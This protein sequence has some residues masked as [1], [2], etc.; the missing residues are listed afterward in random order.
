MPYFSWVGVH[1]NGQRKKGTLFAQSAQELDALLFKQDI[2]LLRSTENGSSWYVSTS[3]N[4]AVKIAFFRQL[5]VLLSAGVLLPQALVIV[6]AQMN[7]RYFQEIIHGLVRDVHHGLSLSQAMEKHPQLFNSL[8]IQMVY[9][10]QESGTL[11]A[12]LGLLS[13]YVHVHQEFQRQ[14][15]S[16][17]L[18]PLI[19][20]GFF[21]VIALVIFMVV[22]PRFAALFASVNHELPYLTKLLI[23]FSGFMASANVLYV[24]IVLLAF[25]AGLTW[26]SRTARGR[27]RIDACYVRIPYVHTIIKNSNVVYFLRSIAMLL[28]AGL[29]VL[30][31]VHMSRHAFANKALAHSSRYVEQEIEAGS[32]L[33]EALALHPQQLFGPEILA[34]VHIGQESG[35]L[36]GMLIHAAT[37][38][39]QKVKHSLAKL[40]TLFQ[41]V[42]MIVLGLLIT[43]LIF[44]IYLPIFN[45]A[46]VIH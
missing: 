25:G 4:N 20:L 39:H 40:T 36:S 5:S 22:I 34:M 3:V 43:M 7:H 31:A 10:G 9:V 44:A 12:S 11:A 29:P 6:N 1:L 35:N 41:P 18:M 45:L 37:E 21:V 16:A 23:A 15:R 13:D 42:L 33:S 8:M 2:A 14:L 24:G 19:T 30:T 28:E 38:Y 32:S 26:Y 46:Q 27:R 17:A